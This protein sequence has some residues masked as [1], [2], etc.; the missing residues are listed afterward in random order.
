[1][2]YDLHI[3]RQDNW[4]D[5]EIGRRISFEEWKGYMANDPE[6]RLDNGELINVNGEGQAAWT[7]YS[8][9]LEICFYYCKGNVIVKGPDDEIIK[10][11]I[12]IAT[13]L[14]ARVQG[15]DGEFYGG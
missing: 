13:M 14:N 9:G 1:M 2:G 7:R 4:F 11:M 10:K 15:D 3:T 5:E 12:E 8:G 6:M